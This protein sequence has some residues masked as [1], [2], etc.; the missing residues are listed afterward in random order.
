MRNVFA[1]SRSAWAASGG[2]RAELI[3][4]LALALQRQK[5]P[6]QQSGRRSMLQWTFILAKGAGAAFDRLVAVIGA[7]S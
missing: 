7:V 2:D 5:V 4:R 6:F 1:L 3:R